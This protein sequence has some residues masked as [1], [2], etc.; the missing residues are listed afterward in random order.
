[1]AAAD[2][3]IANLAASAWSTRFIVYPIE[4]GSLP[5]G[6]QEVLVA[7]QMVRAEEA[8]RRAEAVVDRFDQAWLVISSLRPSVRDQA[9]QDLVDAIAAALVVHS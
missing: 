8:R 1:M 9:R 2:A 3:A 6:N 5:D 7:R 4:H